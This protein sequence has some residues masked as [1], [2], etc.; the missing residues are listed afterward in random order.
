[1]TQPSAATDFQPRWYRRRPSRFWFVERRSYRIFVLRELS[2]LF[3]AWFVVFLLLLVRATGAGPQAYQEFVA[4]SGQPW[5]L[6]LNIVALLFVLLHAVTWFALAPD[7]I[8]LRVRGRRV[9][10][11][12]II[13]AHYAVWAAVSVFV[14]WLLLAA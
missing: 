1:M 3:V 9:S 14:A 2:S 12:S 5:V 8:V 6:A 4:W 11:R 7:A 10:R 13:A